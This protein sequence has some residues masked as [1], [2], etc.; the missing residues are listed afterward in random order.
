M[1]EDLRKRLRSRKPSIQ[2]LFG[3]TKKKEKQENVDPTAFWMYGKEREAGKRQ[4]N[5]SLDVRKRKRSRKT[6]IQRPFGCT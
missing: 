5:G 2:R 1:I 4:S 3:C 6:S